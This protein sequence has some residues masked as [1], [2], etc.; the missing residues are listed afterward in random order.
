MQGRRHETRNLASLKR[1]LDVPFFQSVAQAD[2]QIPRLAPDTERRGHTH[3]LAVV[4][5]TSLRRIY[6][7]AVS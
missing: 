3:R 4:T 2:T 7:L 6:D 1:L 5:S